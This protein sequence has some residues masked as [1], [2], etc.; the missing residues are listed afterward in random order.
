MHKVY[1]CVPF[2]E[3]SNFTTTLCG[4]VCITEVCRGYVVAIATAHEHIYAHSSGTALKTL[5]RH[6]EAN[7]PIP[8]FVLVG[9]SRCCLQLVSS[10]NVMSTPACYFSLFS[11]ITDHIG[12]SVM[13]NLA[14]CSF[15]R[16]RTSRNAK[17]PC[18]P[19]GTGLGKVHG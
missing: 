12:L 9:A 6:N 19:M 1:R 7:H 8:A 10:K 13:V 18:G 14:P 11:I 3:L 17:L 2:H 15:P 16:I 4:Q 5:R